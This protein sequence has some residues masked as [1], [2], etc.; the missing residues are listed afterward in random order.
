VLGILEGKK[1]P[2]LKSR[3]LTTLANP[4]APLQDHSTVTFTFP[5]RVFYSTPFIL[6]MDTFMG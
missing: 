6:L 5:K 3:W 2:M 1:E 4:R